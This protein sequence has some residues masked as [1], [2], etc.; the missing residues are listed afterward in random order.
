[1][2]ENTSTKELLA[3]IEQRIADNQV[4]DA[5]HKIK[6]M[7]ARDVIKELLRG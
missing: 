5:V 2:T 6:F 3:L 7:T 4:K 1:M